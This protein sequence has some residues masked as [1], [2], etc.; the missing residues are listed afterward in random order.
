MQIWIDGDACPK[1]I[2]EIIFKMSKRT[3]INII[4]V[5]NHSTPIP[6]SPHIKKVQVGSGF[7]VVDKYIVANIEPHDLVITAD[8][9]F[10]DEVVT[11]GGFALNPRGELYTE[12]NIKQLLG[13]RNMN[14]SLRSSGQITGGPSKLSPQTVQKF[15]NALDTWIAKYHK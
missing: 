15:A 10:A 6:P 1:A 13:S 14:E 7:D 5:A 11:K 4:I 8:I 2:K 9:P 12:N 3:K